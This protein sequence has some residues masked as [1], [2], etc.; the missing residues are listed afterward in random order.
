MG[1]D[2]DSTLDGDQITDRTVKQLELDITNTPTDGQIV[3]I[4]MPT[5]DMTAIDLGDIGDIIT[6]QTNIVLNAFRIAI[7]GSLTQFNMVDGIV[8]EYEDENSIDNPNS[9]NEEYDSVND[10]YSPFKDN[11]DTSPFTHL[12]LEDATD[13]GTGANSFTNIGTPTFTSGLLN[14][15]LTLDGSTDALNADAMA[16]DIA[17]DA[18]FIEFIPFS[19]SIP[20][21]AAFPL[22]SA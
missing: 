1:T 2:R 11:V 16:V 20:A 3:K 17:S 8:D 6:M 12:K 9:T 19:G 10:L 4:N 7:N 22:K 13:D 18:A 15:A 5:G 14:N 21:C